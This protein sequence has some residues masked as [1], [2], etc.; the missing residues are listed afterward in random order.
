MRSIASVFVLSLLLAS[1]L[2][3]CMHP[4]SKSNVIDK[5]CP[6]LLLEEEMVQGESITTEDLHG[7]VVLFLFYQRDCEGCERIAMPRIQKLHEEFKDHPCARV[8][9]INT[10]FD[11]DIYP[12]LA[13]IV[14]TRKHLIRMDWTMP[15]ARDLDEQTNE[16]F[17]VDDE[18]GTP[19]AVVVNEKGIV[20]AHDWYSEEE[21]MNALD[22]RFRGLAAGMNCHCVRMP[23]KVC[24]SCDRSRKL[25]EEGDYSSAWDAADTIAGSYGYEADEKADAE[26]LKKWIEDTA[27]ESFDTLDREFETDPETAIT[28][29]KA[30]VKR[31]K[32]VTGAED[33]AAKVEG[34]AKSDTLQ[35]FRKD[36]AALEKIAADIKRNGGNVAVDRRKDVVDRLKSIADRAGSNV[37]G[38]DARKHLEGMGVAVESGSSGV[39]DVKSSAGKARVGSDNGGN[40]VSSGGS[41]KAVIKDRAGP[42]PVKSKSPSATNRN[43]HVRQSR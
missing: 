1:A 6:E 5:E 39:A 42:A 8:F 28:N 29:A 10:A 11:K 33:F 43:R 30:I 3:A 20:C 41:S 14:D 21:E 19:Q 26:Y 31:F 16:L 25:I 12:N 2:P 13:D 18:S 4:G 35:N 17:T 36:R 22:A 23:R 37:V 9:V 27:A 15:V 40:K 34:W 24:N 38:S 32:G 7:K